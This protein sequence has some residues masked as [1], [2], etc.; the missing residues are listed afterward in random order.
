VQLPR[1]CNP[2][3][4]AAPAAAH[5]SCCRITKLVAELIRMPW[6]GLVRKQEPWLVGATT[7]LMRHRRVAIG[8]AT[9][10]ACSGRRLALPAGGEDA[11][12][13]QRAPQRRGLRDHRG[14]QGRWVLPP[15]LSGSTR[16]CTSTP[17]AFSPTLLLGPLRHNTC[18]R[19]AVQAVLRLSLPRT[20]PPLDGSL[21][22]HPLIRDSPPSARDP[23]PRPACLCTHG[24]DAAPPPA[25]GPTNCPDSPC[26]TTNVLCSDLAG[27]PV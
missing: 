2:A 13:A 27:V 26:F 24:G 21:R 8:H 11:G 3:S 22:A 20:T 5:C 10:S 23:P 1:C 19:A 15:R 4:E 9:P 6:H 16:T 18:A 25:S 7:L 17:P 14:Q 12:L